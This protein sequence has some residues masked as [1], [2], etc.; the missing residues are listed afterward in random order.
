MTSKRVPTGATSDE[1]DDISI[2]STVGS[3]PQSEYEVETILAQKSFPNGDAYLVKWAGYPLERATWEPEDSFCDPNILLAWRRKIASGEHESLG[4]DVDDLARRI[5]EIESAKLDRRRRRW[6]KRIRLGI[7]AF[8]LTDG[9]DAVSA[10]Q[11]SDSNLDDFIID[12]DVDVEGEDEEEGWQSLRRKR[13]RSSSTKTTTPS[14]GMVASPSLPK[15][16]IPASIAPSSTGFPNKRKKIDTTSTTRSPATNNQSTQS[17]KP[18]SLLKQRQTSKDSQN[19]P[20][21]HQTRPT[22]KVQTSSSTNPSSSEPTQSAKSTAQVKGPL[23]PT[24]PAN[25]TVPVLTKKQNA[26]KPKLFRNL[27]SKNGYEKTMRRDVIPDIRQLDLRPPGKWIA[28]QN[29]KTPLSASPSRLHAPRNSESFVDQNGPHRD[30]NDHSHSQ[31][32][33]GVDG[34]VEARSSC[35]P[36]QLQ[37]ASVQSPSKLLHKGSPSSCSPGTSVLPSVFSPSKANSIELYD[38]GPPK[39]MKG[40]GTGFQSQAKAVVHLRF[41]PTGKEIGDVRLGGLT[42]KT[43]RQLLLLKSQNKIDMHFKDVCNLD[44]YRQLCDRREKT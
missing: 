31:G 26:P 36:D 21:R 14:A 43:V 8:L 25:R 2:T 13:Q 20:A 28:S 33:P 10:G 40:T 16:Q 11:D 24:G 29:D 6:A 34:P 5:E 38:K 18:T 4:V 42:R 37:L 12:D 30:A 44:Q 23:I 15:R 17:S 39:G 3:E 19:A 7:P 22:L 41:G 9:S 32:S 27:S 1:D 35:Q